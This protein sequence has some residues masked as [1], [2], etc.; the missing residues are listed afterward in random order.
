M[1]L[2]HRSGAAFPWRTIAGGESSTHYPSGAAQYH[3]NA[4]IA[5]AV[6]LYVSATG[7]DEFLWDCG[8]DLVFETARVWID[9]GHYSAARRN[10][11]CL[12]GMT[13]PDEYSALV[14]NNY[15]TNKM[16]ALHLAYA[17]ATATRLAAES[18]DRFA[19]VA[20][21]LGLTSDEVAAWARASAAMYLPE[22]SARGIDAQDDSFL[23][24]PEW[25]GLAQGH[26]GRPLLLDVHP[27]VLYRH[28]VSKQADLI[29][30]MAIAGDDVDPARM[31]RNFEYYERVTTHDSTLSWCAFA[32]VAARVGEMSK[33]YDYFVQT[34]KVDV[35]N[36]HGNLGHG[37]HIAALAGSWLVV[38]YGFAGLK[39]R[40]GTLHFQPVLPPTM[41]RPEVSHGMARA[42]H[43]G[44]YRKRRH[45]VPIDRRQTTDAHAR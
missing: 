32:M 17:A 31:R 27:M 8:L 35:E 11:F 2:G 12:F 25:P 5:Q 39:W 15:Y 22:D 36:L 40:S 6:E 16:A 45:H 19:V 21:R 10:R 23:A 44:R 34:A 30:A 20:R 29:L 1:Q 43:R 42:P 4:A 24:K 9:V 28:Q 14:D 37:S 18:P 41:A 33:A 7:D 26:R 38:A 3:I 13:G